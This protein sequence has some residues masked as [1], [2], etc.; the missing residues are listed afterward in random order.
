MEGLILAAGLGTRLRPLTNDRPKALVEIGGRTLLEIN[1]Q[2]MSDAG[3]RR[4]VVNVHHFGDM[5]IDYINSHQWPCEVLVSDER[6]MLLDTGGALR[7]AA[8]LF[9]GKEPVLV[10]NVDIISDIDFHALC[11]HHLA[12][13]NLVTLCASH[14]STKRMLLFD[15]D[16]RLVGRVGEVDDA[17]LIPLAF[18][19][20][21]MISPALFNLLPPDDHPYPVIDTYLELSKHHPIRYFMHSPDRWF[22]VGT[23][24]KLAAA[25]LICGR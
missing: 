12:N 4:C 16:G 20:V 22:D 10:H 17:G 11:R 18:S 24:E 14:R 15:E 7:H 19:G 23:P 6:K 5:F 25:S 8:H 13:D 3:I 1:M 21:S 9:S 2:R